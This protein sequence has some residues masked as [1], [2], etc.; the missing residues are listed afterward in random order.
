MWNWHWQRRRDYGNHYHWGI[1]EAHS[2]VVSQWAEHNLFTPNDGWICSLLST[3]RDLYSHYPEGTIALDQRE[4][5]HEFPDHMWGCGETG[6][7]QL[8][9]GGVAACWAI[10]TASE[11]ESIILLG[12]DTIKAGIAPEVEQAFSPKY[13]E[14]AGFFGIGSF[15]PG[16][17]KEGNHDYAAEAR[18]IGWMAGQAGVKVHFAQDVWP[19]QKS[20]KPRHMIAEE[21]NRSMKFIYLGA[22]SSKNVA[23]CWGHEFKPNEPTHLPEPWAS[24]ARTNRFFL[25]VE[26]NPEFED[27][28]APTEPD[29][30]GWDYDP[31]KGMSREDLIAMA[32]EKGVK[33]DKR[34]NFDKI[35]AAL[36]DEVNG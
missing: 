1:V 2:K 25:E 28:I 8:T 27:D 18:L 32:D 14:S 24:K 17:T 23:T 36:R 13:M 30:D 35:A 5:F 34:W 3:E 4:F 26:E 22:Y 12:F 29:E 16:K 9:R 19:L 20:L 6:G 11:G 10:R 31:F 33:I 21:G 15:A 7:W